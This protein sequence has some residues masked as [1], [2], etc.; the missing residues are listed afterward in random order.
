LSS[1]LSGRVP[2]GSD[3]LTVFAGG[4]GVFANAGVVNVLAGIPIN[5]RVR[6]AQSSASMLR[7][8]LFKSGDMTY[9]PQGTKSAISA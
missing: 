8:Y 5:E 2:P 6:I 4:L 3:R 9:P 7:L 1:K